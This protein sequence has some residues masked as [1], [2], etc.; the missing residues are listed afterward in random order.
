MASSYDTNVDSSDKNCVESCNLQY[1][2]SE[3]FNKTVL[4]QQS[5]KALKAHIIPKFFIY[6]PWK[7]LVII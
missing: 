5:I 7:Y 6:D 3:A 1:G 2:I 4:E